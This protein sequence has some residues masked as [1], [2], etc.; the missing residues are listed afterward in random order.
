M[1]DRTTV[2]PRR[3]MS[4]AES[5]MHV[6]EWM[7][8][9]REDYVNKDKFDPDK[10]TEPVDQ[11][12]LNEFWVEIDGVGEDGEWWRQITQ[13]IQRARLFGLDTPAGRQ[14]LVKATMTMRGCVE[15]SVRVHGPLPKPGVSSGTIIPDERHRAPVDLD[16][17]ADWDDIL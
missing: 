9:E 4:P 16:T 14:A 11:W 10:Q 8:I 7:R 6:E 15:S 13:Y 17:P 1:Q 3:H 12:A 2:R 5:E